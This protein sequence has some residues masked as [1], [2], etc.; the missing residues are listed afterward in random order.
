MCLLFISWVTW[1][2][3][4]TLVRSGQ[5]RTH[6]FTCQGLFP[7]TLKSVGFRI[8]VWHWVGAQ[9]GFVRHDEFVSYPSV[10]FIPLGIEFRLTVVTSKAFHDLASAYLSGF[11]YGTPLL[12]LQHG[13]G[14]SFPLSLQWPIS[15]L[16]PILRPLNQCPLSGTYLSRSLLYSHLEHCFGTQ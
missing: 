7:S 14:S 9:E 12:S 11:I 8:Q 4:I 13:R 15:V 1:S 10:A 16:L 3:F 2:F 6:E 5:W